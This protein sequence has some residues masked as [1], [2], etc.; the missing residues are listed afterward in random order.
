MRQY[1]FGA[2]EILSPETPNFNPYLAPKCNWA[3][4][5][6]QKFPVDVNMASLKNLL[7]VPGIGP[8]SARR[9][10]VARKNGRLGLAALGRMGVVLKRAQYFIRTSDWPSSVRQDKG[11][12]VRALIDPKVYSFGM[13]QLSL[14]GDTPGLRPL[15]AARDMKSINEAVEETV[16]CLASG[17]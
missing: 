6:M 12:T 13:E 8:T 11:M 3:I 17:L 10:V 5:N 14:F 1:G 9:I 4:N 7:R 2:E 16:L 15:P